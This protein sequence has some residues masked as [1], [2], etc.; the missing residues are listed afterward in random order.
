MVTVGSEDA[1]DDTGDEELILTGGPPELAADVI[2]LVSDGAR[3]M[4]VPSIY[5]VLS[6]RLR[7]RSLP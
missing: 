1:C 2:G 5:R 7:R 3:G 6:P 4:P